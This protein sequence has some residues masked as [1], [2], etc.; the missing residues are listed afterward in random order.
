MLDFTNV[1][2]MTV[3]LESAALFL[4]VQPPINAQGKESA[5]PPTCAVVIQDS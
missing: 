5:Y 1:P 3:G 2:V 4:T